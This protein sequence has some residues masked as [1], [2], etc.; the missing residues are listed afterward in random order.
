MAVIINDF[1]I[2]IAQPEG[3]A[4]Q[5]EAAAPAPSGPALQPQD[6][7]DVVRRRLERLARLIAH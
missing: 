6:I 2:I 1:E 4:A 5:A 3:P 7:E